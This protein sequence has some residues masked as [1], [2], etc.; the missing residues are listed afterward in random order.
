M[1]SSMTRFQEEKSRAPQP[2]DW[3]D[4]G[5]SNPVLPEGLK[6]R[7][8]L[9]F[10]FKDACERHDFGYRNYGKYYG[11]QISPT[12]ATK[13]WIDAIFLGDMNAACADSSSCLVWAAAYYNAVRFMAGEAFYAR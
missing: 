4:D 2:Y 11:R 9:L 6:D 13:A 12:D 10:S 1:T 7:P 8:A 5:C 3:T